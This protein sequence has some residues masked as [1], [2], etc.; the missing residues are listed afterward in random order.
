MTNRDADLTAVLAALD[1]PVVAEFLRDY[2]A[3]L[4]RLSRALDANRRGLMIAA[5]YRRP[6]SEQ[7]AAEAQRR[8]A[9]ADMSAIAWHAAAQAFEGVGGDR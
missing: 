5:A 6:L 9:T 8:E 2:A 3:Y 1:P 7:F 4:E